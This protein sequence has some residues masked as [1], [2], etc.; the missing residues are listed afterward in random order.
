[1]LNMWKADLYRMVKGKGF[2][3]FWVLAAFTS[4][5]TIILKTPGGVSFGA[6]LVNEDVKLDIAMAGKNYTFYFL[7]LLPLF[8]IVVADFG[9]KTF[10]NT[11]SSVTNRKAYFFYKCSLAL[12]YVAVV[13]VVANLGFYMINYLVNGSKYTS[14]LGTFLK[15]IFRQLPIFIGFY[16]VLLLIAFV[17]KNSA[18]F[19]AIALVFPF[20]YTA[21]A[22]AVYESI[23]KSFAG[24][25]LLKYELD[26]ALGRLAVVADKEYFR[27]CTILGCGC[28]VVSMI[29]G[30]LVFT[31]KELN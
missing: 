8:N 6:G 31:K 2:W 5:I 18:L 15:A 10:K 27:N 1:M 14:E 24:K 30:Y 17:V 19:N 21:V 13:Y 16:A 23:S 11:I 4:A 22:L 20:V 28:L 29:L 12:I 26:T 9:E 25:Y 7:C 3:L